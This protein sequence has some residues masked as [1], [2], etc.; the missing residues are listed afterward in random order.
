MVVTKSRDD[1]LEGGLA[2][3]RAAAEQGRI[4]EAIYI[5]M[6]LRDR[7]PDVQAVFR[8]AGT[9]LTRLGRRDEAAAMLAMGRERFPDDP[10]LASENSPLASMHENGGSAR[11]SGT[12]AVA[13]ANVEDSIMQRHPSDHAH[14]PHRALSRLWAWAV[15]ETAV[16]HAMRPE[17]RLATEMFRE[18]HATQRDAFIVRIR[19]G[20]VSVDD[21][22]DNLVSA[23]YPRNA[24]IDMYRDYLQDVV[25]RFCPQLRTELLLDVFDARRRN[26][27]VPVFVFQKPIGYNEILLPDVDFFH[28]NFYDMVPSYC[29]RLSYSEKENTA[30]FVGSTTGG[31][32][33]QQVLQDLSL[34]R[35]RAA[36]CF[37]DKSSVVFKLPILA[38]YDDDRTEKLLRQLGH[39]DG[40]RVP[41]EEQFRHKFILSM[42]GNGATCSRV[43]IALKSNGV[44]L[45]YCSPHEL[46]YFSSLEPWTHY[47]PINED[48]EVDRILDAETRR[49][50]LFAHI[51][52]AGKRFADTYL[53]R[54]ST[55]QYTAWLL[56]L[57]E[58][59]FA[60]HD[61]LPQGLFGLH[62]AGCPA[63]VTPEPIVNILAHLQNKGDVWFPANGWI[64]DPASTNSIE[65][66]TAETGPGVPRSDILYCVAF[67]D[68]SISPDTIGGGFVGSRG[69]G[70]PIVGIGMKLAGMTANRYEGYFDM[71]FADG[72]VDSGIPFG[73]VR[74]SQS[75]APVVAFRVGFHRRATP[76]ISV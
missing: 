62:E 17:R 39:G 45:K 22:P 76:I 53:T 12:S 38:Q 56:Q 5:W 31:Y 13:D 26:D 35:L 8:D 68:G 52:A 70:A 63:A 55:M 28:S 4:D 6:I 57:Y 74:T 11:Q 58:S 51:A 42:D 40:E 47:I 44:L 23:A 3:A 46:Y 29:D 75:T 15:K 32:I 10:S 2:R 73:S 30:V 41:W 1:S 65:G 49:P 19:D 60:D 67:A 33:T 72:E 71:A 37:R 43:V 27:P 9:T 66:F 14:M 20:I 24:R 25:K 54:Q 69:L 48:A 50:G 36:A 34:P 64:G 21:K 18:F 61:A 59:S 16:W 7:F